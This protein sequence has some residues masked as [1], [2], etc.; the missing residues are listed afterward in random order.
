[1]AS[2]HLTFFGPVF[3]TLQCV[4]LKHGSVCLPQTLVSATDSSRF[5]KE[6]CSDIMKHGE[7][8]TQRALAVSKVSDAILTNFYY[9]VGISP[10]SVCSEQVLCHE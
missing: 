8:V 6:C 1:M 9:H 4:P 5:L 3:M 7:N 10:L 2:L